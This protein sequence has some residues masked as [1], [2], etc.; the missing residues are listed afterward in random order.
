LFAAIPFLFLAA[1]PAAPAAVSIDTSQVQGRNWGP[2][3]ERDLRK[4]LVA[5]LLEAGYVVVPGPED[6]QV[7]LAVMRAGSGLVLEAS[8][9]RRREY[10]VEPGPPA[11]VALEVLHRATMVVED[12]RIAD[13]NDATPA[14]VLARR[15]IAIVV[16]GAPGDGTPN[17]LRDELAL[18]L[19]SSGFVLAPTSVLHDRTVCLA[20]GTGDVAITTGQGGAGCT[21]EPVVLSR[22]AV[23]RDRLATEVSHRVARLLRAPAGD[24]P[25]SSQRAEAELPVAADLGPSPKRESKAER[26]GAPTFP[27]VRIGVGGGTSARAGGIDPTVQS[28]ADVL[29]ALGWGARLAGG[30]TFSRGGRSLSILE[31]SVQIGPVFRTPLSRQIDLSVGFLGGI[32]VHRFHYDESDNGSRV[33]YDFA[34]PVEA[35]LRLSPTWALGFAVKPGFTEPSPE[36]D[37]SGRIVWARGSYYLDAV[38]GLGVV[39]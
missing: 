28:N 20:V 17:Q 33:L 39:L 24:E 31:P 36:H 7:R 9:V 32:R 6:A 12:A 18:D 13:E 8:G 38:L 37:I 15:S 26:R 2:A 30:F 22:A 11:V 27:E 34:L 25:P 35:T 5:R 1:R 16:T 29:W 21:G 3:E 19:S 4:S 14:G 10:R 23:S